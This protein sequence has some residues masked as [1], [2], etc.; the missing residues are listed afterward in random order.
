MNTDYENFVFSGGGILGIAYLGM[1]EY[2]YQINLIQNIK[3]VA[4]TS[5][6][7]ITAC[8]TS[9]NLPF[10][11]L[12]IISNTLNYNKV[13][14]KNSPNSSKTSSTDSISLDTSLRKD[15]DNIFDNIDCIYRLVKNYGWY[16]S[17][18]FYD[19][20]RSQI[21]LQFDSS[22]KVPPYTF[23]DFMDPSLHKDNRSFKEIY[24]VGTDVSTNTST[25]F[26]FENTPYM[27]VAEAVRISM[28]VPL[29]FEAVKTNIPPTIYTPKVYVD[30][31]FLYNYPINLFDETSPPDL[32]LGAYFNSASPP[33]PINNIVDFIS[34]LLTCNSTLQK[35]LY[36][37]NPDNKNRSIEI[38]TS[39]VKALNF[40]VKPGDYIYL[41]LYQ[42]G[43]QAAVD[44]FDP[45]RY[46]RH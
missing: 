30:G 16:S 43:Y 28:S 31:G 18:Y 15:S 27:E 3:R 17:Y 24:I 46:R 35:K 5:A 21:A 19:W 8:I 22:K 45:F 32:T 25:V 36:Q 34:N 29:L 12:K 6:G 23:A 7:A 39:T 38:Y 9:F 4:G 1:L 20:L 41:F 44:F 33:S 26:S 13:P 37:H 2:L 42:Q 11:E 14:A 10:E 40:D